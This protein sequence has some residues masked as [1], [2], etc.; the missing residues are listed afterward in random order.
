MRYTADG[1][2]VHSLRTLLADLA[3]LTYNVCST[4]INPAATFTTTTRPTPLQARAFE[5]LGVNPG[6]TQ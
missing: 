4:P 1:L 6:C 5:L 2:P 3:T